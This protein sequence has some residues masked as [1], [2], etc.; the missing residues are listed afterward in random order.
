MVLKFTEYI[1]NIIFFF[2][3]LKT[4]RNLVIWNIVGKFS[5]LGCV[6]LR[7]GYFEVR[8]SLW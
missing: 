1:R 5:I 7:I 3:K 2:Y 4:R 6:L 8:P